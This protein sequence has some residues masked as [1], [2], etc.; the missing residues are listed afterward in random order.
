[1]CRLHLNSP[2]M[3]PKQEFMNGL[4]RRLWRGKELVE[5]RRK[6]LLA[7]ELVEGPNKES[8]ALRLL[9]KLML[10]VLERLWQMIP[11]AGGEDD[12][13]V[14]ENIPVEGEI[15]RDGDDPHAFCLPVSH[16]HLQ[17]RPEALPPLYALEFFRHDHIVGGVPDPPCVLG[18]SCA[19]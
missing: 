1:V 19:G 8:P 15:L 13:S 4:R 2:V 7:S 5:A 10:E 16:D 6:F 11:L 17:A 14:E 9:G 18:Y 3:A 12:G